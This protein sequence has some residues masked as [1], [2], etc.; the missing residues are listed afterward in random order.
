MNVELVK[1]VIEDL[2]KKYDF[3]DYIMNWLDE[4]DI[5]ATDTVEDI[6]N[7]IET[8]NEDYEITDAEIIY[9]SNAIEYL[10]E[11]DASLNESLDIAKEF[12]YTIA[13][14]N[15]ELLASLLKSRYNEDDFANFLEEL[16]KTLKE[17][18]EE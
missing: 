16:E 3:N 12:G 14:L 6:I 4:E 9:Y 1:T 17:Y 2:E 15:S 13:D 10:A 11:N 8:A 5:E 18:S 7:L